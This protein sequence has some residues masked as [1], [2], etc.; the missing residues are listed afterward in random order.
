M[1]LTPSRYAGRYAAIALLVVLPTAI[2]VV[3]AILTS[4][5][6]VDGSFDSFESV[7]L[8][9]ASPLG[10]IV[11]TL[12]P[13]AALGLAILPVFRFDLGW[14]DGRVHAVAELAI[15][16]LNG[17]VALLSGTLIIVMAVYLLVENH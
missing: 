8:L 14:R 12:A 15:P 10:A 1:S 16:V 3:L 4:S 11:L 9:G 2:F 13:Y 17:L 6:G 5:L 7:S